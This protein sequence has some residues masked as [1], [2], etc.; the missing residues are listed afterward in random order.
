VAS[1]D[2][3]AHEMYWQHNVTQWEGSAAGGMTDLKSA[4]GKSVPFKYGFA[5]HSK[6]W[7]G[8]VWYKYGWTPP[9]FHA[10]FSR[11]TFSGSAYPTCSYWYW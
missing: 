10:W 1:Y 5:L 9:S 2:H 7:V 8:S 11:V 4:S 6:G 3:A